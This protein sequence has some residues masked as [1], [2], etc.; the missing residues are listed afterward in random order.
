ML[1]ATI[2]ITENLG[3]EQLAH[4]RVAG[5]SVAQVG[6]ARAEDLEDSRTM[7][8]ARLDPGATVEV[9]D[10]VEI[11]IDPTDRV[12]FFDRDTGDSLSSA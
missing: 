1:R 10:Q 11:S 8:T 3:P 12:A 9:G 5:L 4:F 6:E 2:E 7:L